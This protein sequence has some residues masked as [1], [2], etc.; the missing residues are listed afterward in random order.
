MGYPTLG[1]SPAWRSA[2]PPRTIPH[3][4]CRTG[5]PLYGYRSQIHLA[6]PFQPAIPAENRERSA[7]S[8]LC[9]TITHQAE[10]SPGRSAGCVSGGQR[11]AV[12]RCGTACYGI[13]PRYLS[14][15]PGENRART[16]H[17]A[18]VA[19][20]PSVRPAR[21]AI[22]RLPDRLSPGV[23]ANCT[24]PRSSA[25]FRSSAFLQP[26]EHLP[27]RYSP[28]TVS[29]SHT[30][31]AAARF[32]SILFA[33]ACLLC[34]SRSSEMWPPVPKYISSGVCPRKA[35]WGSRVLCSLT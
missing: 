32:S 14:E 19:A 8:T 33:R 21:V 7:E 4:T 25:S 15:H 30:A 1:G 17:P 12:T 31:H 3:E 6:L 22:S 27:S 26:V 35:E 10:G 20:S 11:G 24:T 13:A 34:T 9:S 23:S 5:S 2:T 16:R 28:S 18:R 29:G